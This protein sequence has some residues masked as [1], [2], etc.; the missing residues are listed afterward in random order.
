MQTIIW[1]SSSLV[2]L[3]LLISFLPLGFTLRGKFLIVLSSCIISLVGLAAVSTIPYWETALMLV[4]LCFFVAYFMHNRI[5]PQ[6]YLENH[7]FEHF[8]EDDETSSIAFQSNDNTDVLDKT[9]VSEVTIIDVLESRKNEFSHSLDKNTDPGTVENDH[10]VLIDE[11]VSFL[12]ERNSDKDENEQI[13]PSDSEEGYLSDIESLLVVESG[14]DPE[15]VESEVL[16][17]AKEA[18]AGQEDTLEEFHIK[19]KI[20]LQK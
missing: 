16:T 11:D 13:V 20:S 18:A 3:I 8:E 15:I 19:S 6:L 12:W 14:A 4:V 7:Q 2:I 9:K 5:G 17:A 1:I 10:H